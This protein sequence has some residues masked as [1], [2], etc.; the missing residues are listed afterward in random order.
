MPATYCVECGTTVP[1]GAAFCPSCG[2]PAPAS[3]VVT[4]TY[5]APAP[6]VAP[7]PTSIPS[8]AY[9][10]QRPVT[11][12]MATAGFVLSLV[13]LIFAILVIPVILA[14]VFSSLG[15]SKARELEEGGGQPVGR[16]LAIAGLVISLVV[17]FFWFLAILV[18]V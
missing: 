12:G 13:S 3:P 2:K 11:N 7:A 1:E 6:P 9:V 10:Y 5:L 4:P 14:I 18:S 15:I 16:G 17:A 8:P